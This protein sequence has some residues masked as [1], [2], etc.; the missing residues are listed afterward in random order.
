MTTEVR[1]F[2]YLREGR[3]NRQD[4]DLPEPTSLRDLLGMLEIP[5]ERVSLPLINGKYCDLAQPLKDGDVVSL[6]PPVAGG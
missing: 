2:A 4:M 3:F 1:L 5:P 6:F